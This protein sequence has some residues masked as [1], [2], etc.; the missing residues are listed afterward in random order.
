MINSPIE[1]RRGNIPDGWKLYSLEE[2]V[3]FLDNQR[4]PIKSD[5]RK[6]IAGQ[7]PYYG[8]SG[9]ID[10]VDQYLFDE[11][12]ILLGEDGANIL[13]RSSRL[14][15]KV[16]GKTWVNNHA[17]VLR[18]KGKVH[19]DFLTEYLE[20][21]DYTAI[22]NSLSQPKLN[23][24]ECEK[25]PIAVPSYEVQKRIGEI[26]ST[27]DETIETLEKLI[28]AKEKLKKGLM[29]QLLTGKKRLPGFEGE[30]ETKRL[31]AY[32]DE[33]VERGFNDLELL[34]VSKEGVHSQSTSDKR[35]ISNK[36]KSKYKRV[37][38]GDIAYNTMRMWQG[39]SALSSLEGIVSPAYT[40]LSPKKDTSSRFFAY[41]FKLPE[42]VHLF[43]RNSYGLV[44]DTLNCKY[45]DFKIIKVVAPT[46]KEQEAI[47]DVFDLL[48]SE[49]KMV[50][51][52]RVLIAQQKKGLMQQLLTGKVRV[53]FLT[54]NNQK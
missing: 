44:S 46:F 34:S 31:G 13:D 53:P 52:K 10:W 16:S 38:K 3:E 27:W 20:S 15:F 45:K 11:E 42:V 28:T 8:A 30:W 4:R 21:Y 35:D 19:I 25:L 6:K 5:D 14:S 41:L 49:I 43:Y 26:L 54:V 1:I 23:K 47:A 37:C 12:L 7:Y 17:H 32:F 40:I 18:P 2:L 29:Q 50:E 9:I 33:R 51:K 36:D 24:A 48:D 39:R 22:N